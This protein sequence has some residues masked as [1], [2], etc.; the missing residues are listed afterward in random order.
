MIHNPC[1]FCT[2]AFIYFI[3]NVMVSILVIVP[4]E[5][6]IP[7][8][9]RAVA[10][11]DV[12]DVRFSMEC[13]FGTDPGML[14]HLRQYDIVVVRGMT[15][16]ALRTMFPE[17]HIIEINM[18]GADVMNSLAEVR[19]LYGAGTHVGLIVTDDTICYPDT[20][21]ELTGLNVNLRTAYGDEELRKAA[22]E[23]LDDGCQVL[24]G[25]TT[26]RAYCARRSIPF[27]LISTG[28]S[29][30]KES[31]GDAIA[32]AKILQAER[33]R[34]DLMRRV[35]D[36]L[37]Y[38]LLAVGPNGRIVLSNSGAEGFYDRDS[39]IGLP[40]SELYSGPLP[41]A[42]GGEGVS[43][44]IVE[45]IRGEKMLVSMT[46]TGGGD[47]I[48][49]MHDISRFYNGSK[50]VSSRLQTR[51]LRARYHFSDIIAEHV[52]MRQLIAKA[53]R[54]AEA[55]GNVLVIGETGTGKEL[56]VQSMHNA[57]KRADGPFVA[58]NCAAISSELLESELFGYSEGAFTGARKGGRTGL[59]ELADKG[60]I[61]LDEIGEMPIQLQTKLLR[62]LQEKEIRRVG[63]DDEIPVDVRV[64]CATNQ[65]IPSLIE[66]GLFRRDLYYRINLL[67][68]H[69]PPLR[70][71]GND[72]GLLFRH[73]VRMYAE[74]MEITPPPVDS[75]AIMELHRYRWLGNIRELRNVAERIVV[76]NGSQRIT[77]LSIKNIDIP[78]SERLSKPAAQK[79]A[80]GVDA[81][82]LY[83]RFRSSGMSL[84]DF[85]ASVGISRTT[86]WR[87]FKNA[88]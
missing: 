7:E 84:S 40:I 33:S 72:I 17:L 66:K 80:K 81:D 61:F 77:D 82:E 28:E 71:R 57:S 20:I 14:A 67:T 1:G 2:I 62:V 42:A 39:L 11:A 13:C 87:R 60:T 43:T 16:H 44:E 5:D 75:S 34:A 74:R 36:S 27:C 79:P 19:R 10:A 32:A 56:F 18:S 45:E 8:Y 12:P 35:M 78:E 58:V 47:T 37:P 70:D 4:Y 9:E 31:I 21:R 22:D 52:T 15:Y 85:A 88:T 86:L 65:D 38:I 54:Y 63:G 68:I 64:M 24:V 30:I 53:I 46:R 6:I 3:M 76:L 55:D 26:L 73:F 23:L 51:G 41:D 48:M 69:I 49:S 25:G 50:T 59:F 83:S 29:A